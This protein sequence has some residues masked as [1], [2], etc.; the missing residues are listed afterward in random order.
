M[1]GAGRSRELS[2]ETPGKAHRA[3]GTR[4]PGYPGPPELNHSS[5]QGSHSTRG[6][7]L[8]GQQ[9]P[10]A[11]GVS[12]ES[13]EPPQRQLPWVPPCAPHSHAAASSRG[14]ACQH[15]HPS[16]A[17]VFCLTSQ[18]LRARNAAF[19]QLSCSEPSA[20]PS[21]GPCSPLP[22]AGVQP[23]PTAQ[24][25]REDV[26]AR[27]SLCGGC[28][29]EHPR[30]GRRGDRHCAGCRRAEPGSER[31]SP[32]LCPCTREPSLVSAF[33]VTL[34][35]PNRHL[36]LQSLELPATAGQITEQVLSRLK[37][38]ARRLTGGSP[39]AVGQAD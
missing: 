7:Q 28:P 10:R 14:A 5:H 31:H 8:W 11:Q 26:T 29:P 27:G 33:T 39:A 35:P 20:C 13:P 36:C 32:C 37:G 2:K 3:A 38:S 24:G 15:R 30:Y 34:L 17:T 25:G 9:C 16:V 23:V 4:S 18:Q 22:P 21:P 12:W 1:R 6:P 19:P